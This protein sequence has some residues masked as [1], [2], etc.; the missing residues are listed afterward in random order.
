MAEQ[1][2]VSAGG[3]E[4]Y[5]ELIDTGGPATPR[6]EGVLSFEG[7][8]STVEGIANELSQAWRDARPDEVSVEF[9]LKLTARSGKLTGLV[10]QGGDASLKVVLAWKEPAG[11]KK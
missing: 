9:G 7:V 1:K 8:R 11:R 3:S 10:V 6:T 4:F 2:L 5:V